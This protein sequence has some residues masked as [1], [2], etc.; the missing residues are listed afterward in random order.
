MNKGEFVSYSHVYTLFTKMS[1]EVGFKIWPH[2]MRHAF[3]TR[4]F[5]TPNHNSKN[6]MNTFDGY[7]HEIQHC[8]SWRYD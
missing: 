5:N 3:S 4:S 2:K 6:I 1:K 7:D 8:D